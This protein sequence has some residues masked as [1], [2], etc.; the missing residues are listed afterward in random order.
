MP[1]FD[2]DV[3]VDLKV[4]M[5]DGVALSADVYRPIGGG[6][7]PTL[8]CR[9]PYD[10]QGLNYV[11]WALDFVAHGYAVVLQ[12]CRGRYDSDGTW[13]PY[14]CEIEDGFDTQQWVGAQA[15]CNGRVGTFGIS[16]VGFTQLLPAALRS[17]YVQAL[18]P[19]ANQEDNFGHMYYD[20][21][22]QLQ[23][24]VNWGRLGNRNLQNVPFS[25]VDMHRLYRHLPLSS[26]LDGVSPRP[27]YRF[28]L[29]HPTF[30]EYWKSYSLKS[31]YT[32][33]DTPAMFLTGWYDNLVHE[34]FKC[35]KGFSTS[36]RSE[37]TRTLTKLVVGPWM[38]SGIGSAEP[39]GDIDF[40]ETARVDIPALHRRWYDRR[41]KDEPNGIDEEPPLK[42]FVMGRNVWRFEGE[43]PLARTQFTPY[44]LHS[45]GRANSRSGDGQLSRVAP[46]DEAADAF[47]YDP[48]DP[49]PTVG[50]QSMFPE[51]T[52]PRDR[53]QLED[54]ADVLVYTTPGLTED[55]EVT[56]P[57]QLTLYAES[58]AV[59]TDFTATLVDV[60]P[61]GVAINICDGITRARFRES[62]EQPTP[63]EPGRVYEYAITLWETSNVF[64]AG[65][66][67]RLEVSSSNFPRFDRNLNSGEELATGTHITVAHQRVLHSAQY[68]SH[69]TLPIVPD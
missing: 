67:I 29:S 9:T 4:P 64:L 49:V 65:H 31:R 2:V 30:D 59:D 52:G 47:A 50:G 19:T 58:S 44:Y 8:L 69:L 51:N 17:P 7:F 48:D 63:I 68:P 34:Q 6:A 38:H 54:R 3:Q 62:V 20:G 36:A 35:F 60:Y 18:V 42:L 57:I 40:T 14:V 1:Q 33:I 13:D 46:G 12:D 24:V 5:R 66:A 25:Y 32:E 16:Y 37:R 23:N 21:V 27:Q 61:S 22:M 10:N 39:F 55:V 45:G 43:W 11:A 26:A 41:L 56:G 28:F 53:Q 15:W